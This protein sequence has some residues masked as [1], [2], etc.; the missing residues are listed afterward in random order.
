ML[1]HRIAR[2]E[3]HI[4]YES[5]VRD[6]HELRDYHS[7]V[8]YKRALKTA[9]NRGAIDLTKDVLIDIIWE[10]LTSKEIYD[11]FMDRC[12]IDL[13]EFLID[14]CPEAFLKG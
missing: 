11:I 5:G 13:T 7:D 1:E 10:S 8:D 2:L 12:E 3:K 4:K 6:S 9:S 14:V